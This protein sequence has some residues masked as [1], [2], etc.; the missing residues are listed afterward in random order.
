MAQHDVTVV[1]FVRYD[2]AVPTS[3]R[4]DA[5]ETYPVKLRNLSRQILNT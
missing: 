1:D 5:K 3:E 4:N 2:V